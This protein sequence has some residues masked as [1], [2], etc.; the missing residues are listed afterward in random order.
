MIVSHHKVV[1]HMVSSKINK[2][3]QKNPGEK[4]SVIIIC[5]NLSG[6]C[7]ICPPWILNRV[8]FGDN[9]HLW[10]MSVSHRSQ[11]NL[12]TPKILITCG[13]QQNIVT[14]TLKPNKKSESH[15]KRGGVCNL[16]MTLALS[17]GINSSLLCMMSLFAKMCSG[18]FL[19]PLPC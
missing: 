17:W 16:L 1:L 13:Q 19:Q 7:L 15:K 10:L 6:W 4:L 5:S 14:S 12:N 11:C 2:C 3:G 9:L 18:G 8:H